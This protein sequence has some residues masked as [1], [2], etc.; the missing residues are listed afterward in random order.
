MTHYIKQACL[1]GF[2]FMSGI[3][4]AATLPN[5]AEIKDV[6]QK[7][8]RFF[9]YLKPFAQQAN[10]QVLKE[11]QHL[12][13]LKQQSSIKPKE[14]QWLKGISKRYQVKIT[15]TKQTIA[16][17]LTKVDVVPTSLLLAQAANESAWGTSRFARLG[18][19]LFGQWCYSQ[20]CGMVPK[21]RGKGQHHE[22]KKFAS[23]YDS[24]KAYQLNLNRN[25]SYTKLRQIRS[26]LRA[27]GQ[28]PS[29]I[30]LALGLSHYSE[31]GMAYVKNIQ[32]MIRSNHLQKFD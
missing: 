23:P 13:K 3:N 18:N 10:N 19:N 24:I 21:R 31:R 1:L 14:K 22:V 9:N 20:H 17:L 28:K 5:F 16:E 4:F 27:Q 6:K 7:K 32:S 11:R 12:L 30:Q 26:Q 25:R 8:M 29:G 15:Q 2:V